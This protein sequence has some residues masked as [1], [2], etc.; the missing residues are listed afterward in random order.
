MDP[1]VC[2]KLNWESGKLADTLVSPK[3]LWTAERV[4]NRIAFWKS[5]K[6]WS[7]LRLEE[8]GGAALQPLAERRRAT[9]FESPNPRRLFARAALTGDQPKIGREPGK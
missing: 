9:A 2:D 5:P 3:L 4:L 8:V 6:R 7:T 1:V